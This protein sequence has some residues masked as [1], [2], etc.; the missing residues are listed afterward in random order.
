MAKDKVTL[1][2]EIENV[3]TLTLKQELFCRAYAKNRATFGNATLAYAYAYNYDFNNASREPEKDEEGKEIPKSSDYDRL[4]NVCA[5]CGY[6][7]L[8]NEKIDTRITKLLNEEMNDEVV[9]AELAKV[10][11][12][13]GRLDAK[14]QA[15]KEYNALK[16]RIIKKN[17][18]TSG[19]KSIV[20]LPPEILAKHNLGTSDEA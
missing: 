19:G 17:D 4:M 18:V 10:I 12:Q 3:E 7:L 11:K 20:V 16:G 5:V 9:D 1:E 2:E 6:R 13:D 14:V 8:R 15:V